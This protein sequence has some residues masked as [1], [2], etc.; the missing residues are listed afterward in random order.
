MVFGFAFRSKA[1]LNDYDDTSRV[2]SFDGIF[3]S[4]SDMVLFRDAM[5]LGL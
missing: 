5:A 3:L 2:F 4:H 1:S